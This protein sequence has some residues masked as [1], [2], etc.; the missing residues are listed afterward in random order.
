MLAIVLLLLLLV[1][2]SGWTA[3]Y[4]VATT[5]NDNNL[6]SAAQSIASPKRTIRAGLSCPGPGDTLYI[7]GGTY[8]EALIDGF[9]GGTSWTAP[10]TIKA[11]PGDLGVIIQPPSVAYIM[12]LQQTSEQYIIFDSLIFDGTNRTVGNVVVTGYPPCCT[13]GAHHIRFVNCEFR[14][15]TGEISVGHTHHIEF[16][17]G[18]VHDSGDNSGLRHG[19]YIGDAADILIDGM[20]IYNITGYGVHIYS[21]GDQGGTHTTDRA[22]IR[23]NRVYNNGTARGQCGILYTD[24]SDG[25]IYNNLVYNNGDGSSG[26]GIAIGHAGFATN[27][28]VYNNTVTGNTGN[29][30]AIYIQS[31]SGHIIRNNI[32]WNNPGADYTV[33]SGSVTADHNLMGV[34]PLFV[35]EASRDFHLQVGSPAINAGVAISQVVNDYAATPRSQGAGY[36]I[37]AYAYRSSPT[38]VTPPPRNLRITV[39]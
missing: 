2:A 3:T 11:Y 30:A 8:P 35:N 12:N 39:P 19:F 13:I 10:V 31:G 18:S 1:P 7:R 32:L 14:N 22:I 9:P 20:Q 25:F 38:P 27:I 24:G 17:G 6:C 15:T 36:D 33:L 34:N 29:P 21:G 37:G 16:I 26:C 5:G 23:N 4:Y 28:G